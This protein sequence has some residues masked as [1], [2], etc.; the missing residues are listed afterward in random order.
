MN[1]LNRYILI[2]LLPLLSMAFCLP[3]SAATLAISTDNDGAF[4][5]D[6]D[7]SSGLFLRWSE[8]FGALGYG[9]ELGSQLWTPSNIEHTLPQPNERPYAGL[10]FINLRLHHQT[11]FITNKASFMLGRIG[12]DSGAKK[13]QTIVHSL[14]GSPKPKGWEYQIYNETVYQASLE[15]HLLLNHSPHGEF[16]G[17]SRG[18]IGNFQPEFAVGAT[19]R[20]GY[21]LGST[22]GSV[23]NAK[24][25]MIDASLLNGYSG[26]F[27]YT[28]VEAAYRFYD[29][30]IEGKQPLENSPI[31]MKH[32]HYAISAGMALYQP[33]WGISFSV[34]AESETFK[35]ATYDYHSYANLMYFYRFGH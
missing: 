18:Q 21:D 5:S 27:V 32:M 6:K 11:N 24:G 34:I 28:S 35:Q 10:T 23:S 3:I 2:P 25:N 31:A 14:V 26:F 19:Y 29:I 20:L 12:P 8:S 33:R 4:N 30:T 1:S 13:A 7:Y 9:I 16:S 22:F 17:Y 15:S